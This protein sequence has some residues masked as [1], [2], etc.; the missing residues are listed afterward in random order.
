MT[1]KTKGPDYSKATPDLV[2]KVKEVIA[3]SK[4][5]TYSVSKVYGAYNEAYGLNETPQSCTS[6]LVNRAVLL[7]KW[8]EGYDVWAAQQVPVP[9]ESGVDSEQDAV[10]PMAEDPATTIE[11]TAPAEEPAAPAPKMVPPVKGKGRKA[12]PVPVAE[13]EDLT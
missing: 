3:D 11:E 12:A 4:K 6:C 10:P 1:N 8:L 2:E 5:R 13:N 9:A 7:A